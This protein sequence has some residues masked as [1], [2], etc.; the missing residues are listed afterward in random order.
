MVLT[1]ICPQAEDYPSIACSFLDVEN[2]CAIGALIPP[3]GG[4]LD[5]IGCHVGSFLLLGYVLDCGFVY[6]YFGY[7]ILPIA[8]P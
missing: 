4:A 5:Y 2:D 1:A 7:L 3:L 6:P 8:T